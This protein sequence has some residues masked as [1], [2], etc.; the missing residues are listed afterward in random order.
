MFAA[1]RALPPLPAGDL[2]VLREDN[3]SSNPALR[4]AMQEAGHWDAREMSRRWLLEDPCYMVLDGPRCVHYSW[5]SKR[6]L[7]I[8]EIGYRA[9]LNGESHWLYNSYTSP[10]HRGRSI[11]PEVLQTMTGHALARDGGVVWAG[12]QDTNAASMKGVLR[13]GFREAFI[14]E[15]KTFLS[16]MESRSSRTVVDAGM[17]GLFDDLTCVRGRASERHGY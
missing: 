12:V 14:L 13:A 2:P 8:S 17:T 15:K 10:T 6:M 4:A 1:Q 3:A 5:M 11:F 7:I 9:D 16:S